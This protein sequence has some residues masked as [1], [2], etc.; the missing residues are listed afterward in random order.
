MILITDKINK[1]AGDILSS[2]AE[3]DFIETSQNEKIYFQVSETIA[4]T[5]TKNREL[6]S[7]KLINDNYEK[8]LITSDKSFILDE[9][10][11][12]FKN[13]IDWLLE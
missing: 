7:L 4:N 1:A 13:I 5:E 8:Y 12:K 10:G 9:D 2:V 3:V 11:I 6:A